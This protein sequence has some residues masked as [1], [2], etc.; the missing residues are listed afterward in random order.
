MWTWSSTLVR[1]DAILR[2]GVL[3]SRIVRRIQRNYDNVSVSYS[4]E[5]GLQT[6]RC[7]D[8]SKMMALLSPFEVSYELG[9]SLDTNVGRHSKRLGREESLEAGGSE[10]GRRG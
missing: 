3:L 8:L 7:Y 4:V 2:S 1:F 5:L 9:K 6:W 10:S